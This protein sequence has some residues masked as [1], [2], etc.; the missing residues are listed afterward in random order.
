MRGEEDEL[1]GRLDG[2]DDDCDMSVKIADL[3]NACWTFHK[4]VVDVYLS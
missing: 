3:G 1:E 2:V 4:L